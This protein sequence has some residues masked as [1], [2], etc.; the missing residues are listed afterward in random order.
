MCLIVVATKLSQ[1]L[2]GIVRHP[3]SDSDPS[4]VKIDWRKWR[5]AMTEKDV[6][7]LRRGEEIMV[8]D[9]EVLNM[10]TEAMDDYMDWYQRTFLDDRPSKSKTLPLRFYFLLDAD[11]RIQCLREFWTSFHFLT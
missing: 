2:D 6:T 4:T 5:E 7:G 8:T 10:S 3:E 11:L 9:M 1:P